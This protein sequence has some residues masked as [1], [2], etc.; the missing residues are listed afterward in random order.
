MHLVPG[1]WFHREEE[2]ALLLEREL[3]NKRMFSVLSPG[4]LPRNSIVEWRSPA[5]Y[6][7]RDGLKTKQ[8]QVQCWC[9]LCSRGAR[10]KALKMQPTTEANMF[11]HGF[12]TVLS[13]CDHFV[14]RRNRSL[15]VRNYYCLFSS[16]QPG[17]AY[18][19][20]E[21]EYL[22]NQTDLSEFSMRG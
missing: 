21:I 1:S 8:Q 13:L 17:R 3:L 10:T 20:I 7:I 12:P 14:A 22:Q 18:H 2:R 9:R 11:V 16:T 15:S 4:S 6:V 5:I 19:S